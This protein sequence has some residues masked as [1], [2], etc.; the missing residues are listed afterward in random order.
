VNVGTPGLRITPLHLAARHGHVET[1]V[2]L[3]AGGANVNAHSKLYGT[4]L[5]WAADG[6]QWITAKTLIAHGANK[7]ALDEHL[8]TPAQRARERGH[9][10]L[11]TRLDAT[12]AGSAMVASNPLPTPPEDTSDE[13]CALP[14]RM[15]SASRIFLENYV[16]G[17]IS[18]AEFRRWFSMPNSEYLALTTCLQ[19]LYK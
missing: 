19:E 15:N 8:L 7:D 4:P 5:H 1:I 16:G 10:D 11:A 13:D 12:D 2:V 9:A 17:D 18:I 6:G 3:L 14:R